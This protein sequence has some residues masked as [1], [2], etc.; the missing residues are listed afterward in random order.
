MFDFFHR[1]KQPKPT[2]VNP[3]PYVTPQIQTQS[4]PIQ[5]SIQTQS[6]GQSSLQSPL[7]LDIQNPI[8]TQAQNSIQTQSNNQAVVVNSRVS[9]PVTLSSAQSN[10]TTNPATVTTTTPQVS[11]KI[12]S[13][14]ESK[15][16]EFVNAIVLAM[17]GYSPLDVD[18][19]ERE[20]VVTDCI[21][22]FSDYLIKFVELQYGVAD[23]TRLKASQKFEDQTVFTKFSELGPKFDA[24][25]DSFLALLE[26]QNNLQPA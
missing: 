23:A 5:P 17:T 1:N 15:A 13:E 25:Y 12:F 2:T 11:G 21:N 14:D 10:T 9:I 16:L 6:N 7:S 4:Q 8:Q 20:K 18:I 3:T 26:K 22:I 24:A 19:S